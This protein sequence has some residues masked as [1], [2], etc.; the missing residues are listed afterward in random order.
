MTYR[1]PTREMVELEQDAEWIVGHLAGVV[2]HLRQGGR[3]IE[4]QKYDTGKPAGFNLIPTEARLAMAAVLTYGE[5]KYG[6]PSGWR[7]VPNAA[8]RYRDALDRHILAMDAGETHDAESGLPH[9]W[10]AL[11]NMAFLV[12]LTPQEAMP[13]A[14]P[15]TCPPEGVFVQ[16][17]A[18]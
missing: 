5:Q 8:K 1:I 18:Q 11:T 3:M 2:E 16:R 15:N 10:H 14:P 4:G 13:S 12:A 6:A 7:N 9:L 17:V